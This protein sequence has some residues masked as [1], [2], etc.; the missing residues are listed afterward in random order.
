MLKGI[1]ASKNKINK[2]IGVAKVL[3]LTNYKNI[4]VEKNN[5]LVITHTFIDL[6][7]I[8]TKFLC[9]ITERGGLLSHAAIVSRELGIPCIVGVKNVIKK[10]KSGDR[11]ELDLKNGIVKIFK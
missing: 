10:V 3:D 1:V 8:M 7:S 6:E 11:L 2:I 9:I 4:V 5:I